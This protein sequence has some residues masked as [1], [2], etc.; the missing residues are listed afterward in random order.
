MGVRWLE[1]GPVVSHLVG[2]LAGLKKFTDAAENKTI[3]VSGSNSYDIVCKG[4]K[5]QTSS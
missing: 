1:N 2:L 5:S 3:R 4:E